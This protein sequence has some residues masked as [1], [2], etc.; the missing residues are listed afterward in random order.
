[1]A[2]CPLL[3]QPLPLRSAC[4]M[5]ACGCCLAVRCRPPSPTLSPALTI[6]PLLPACLPLC[7]PQV[8]P[9]GDLNTE[10]ERALGKLVKEKYNTGKQGIVWQVLGCGGVVL[11]VMQNVRSR[12]TTS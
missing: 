9:F 4:P 7:S 12:R 5:V 2:V 8:D 6:V 10:L 1:M 3:Q 11:N